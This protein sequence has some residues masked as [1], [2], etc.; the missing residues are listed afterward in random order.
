MIR[1][2]ILTTLIQRYETRTLT[3][4]ALS[5]GAL[6][7]FVGVAEEMSEGDLHSFDETVL[8]A[9]RVAGQPDNPIG[10]PEIEIAMRDL[11]ALGGVTVLTVMT[12]S[13]M[14]YLILA[15]QKA[16]AAFLGLAIVG[17]QVISGLAKFGFDRP[18][19]DLVSHAVEV[20]S[21]SFPSGHSMMAAV[22]YL[23]LAV[24]LG[25]AEPRA[26]IRRFYIVLAGILALLVGV[27]RVYLGVHWPS[28]VLAGWSL[29]AAWA[30]GVA[31]LAEHMARRGRIES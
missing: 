30:L 5:A 2:P 3:M 17:G 6:W 29:G 21:S 23:T 28:D 12:L 4:I 19:P 8:L 31:M 24:M 20:S 25:R 9:L 15:R 10:G 11:T 18:R 16:S 22:T 1:V 27:S 26:S 14:T 13:V 7:G